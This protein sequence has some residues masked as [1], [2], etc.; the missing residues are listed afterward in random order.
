M[1]FE[2]LYRPT[3]SLV[4]VTLE[5]N[6]EINA[7]AGAMAYMDHGME[8]Q[9]AMKGGVFG[10]LKRSFLGGESLFINTFKG[11]GK[12]GLSTPLIGDIEHMALDGTMFLQ[13]GGYVA[14]SQGINIDTKWGGAKTFFGR[15]GLFLLKATGRGDLFFST[16]GAVHKV[17]MAD[18]KFIVDTGHIVAFTDGLNFKLRKVGGLKSSL[19]GGEGLVAEF[20]GSGSLYIQTKSIDTF[21]SWLTPFLPRPS[22]S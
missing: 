19:L 4:E 2:I 3:N 10:A 18:G 12:L 5:P 9:T 16:F 11:P 8:M 7:E 14:S 22:S 1:K 6:E 17:E 13:G 21:I 15:E 20:S